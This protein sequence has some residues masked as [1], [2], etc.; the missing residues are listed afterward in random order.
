MQTIFKKNLVYADTSVFGGVFDPEFEKASGIFI[1][2]VRQ[3]RF[4]L[5]TSPMVEYEIDLAPDNVKELYRSLFAFMTYTEPTVETTEL[6]KA[7]LDAVILSAKSE[8]DALHV[9]LAVTSECDLIVSWNFKHIV[10][11]K[12]IP[13]YNAVSLLKG[14]NPIQIFSPWEVIEDD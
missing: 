8:E 3:G 4:E 12:K 2:Q 6:Q 1:S 7:Y 11:F 9:A 13:M 14:Y 5:V 10:N